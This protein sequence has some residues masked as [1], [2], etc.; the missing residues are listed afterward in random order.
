MT[1]K[2]PETRTDGEE[3]L[4]VLKGRLDQNLRVGLLWEGRLK[5]LV[6]SLGSGIDLQKLG[7]P[8]RSIGL[9]LQ[10]SS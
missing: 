5:S 1:S 6:F 7:E 3:Y 2:R 10:Y 8:F 9:E 4:G